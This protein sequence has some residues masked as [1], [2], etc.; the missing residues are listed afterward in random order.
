MCNFLRSSCLFF[1]LIVHLAEN[2][3]PV[4]NDNI[5]IPRNE[6]FA[7]NSISIYLFLQVYCIELDLIVIND[8]T[9]EKKHVHFTSQVKSHDGRAEIAQQKIFSIGQVASARSPP[10]PRPV[11]YPHYTRKNQDSKGKIPLHTR[12]RILL[13]SD[14][15]F[16]FHASRLSTTRLPFRPCTSESTDSMI[17]LRAILPHS[18]QLILPLSPSHAVRLLFFF[19][20]YRSFIQISRILLYFT[21]II[22]GEHLIQTVINFQSCQLFP[23]SAINVF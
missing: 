9:I 6:S 21:L 5:R 8:P 22:Q 7:M 4:D 17:P 10:S 11:L 15:N 3:S 13:T 20:L 18:S 14:T 12:A 1:L 19:S 2:F 23:N 16:Y